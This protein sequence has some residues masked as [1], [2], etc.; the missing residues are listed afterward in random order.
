VAH[1]PLLPDARFVLEIEA[2]A[3]AFMR[4]LNFF[5]QSQGSF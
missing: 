4:T 3:L 1:T 2:Q 5:Q